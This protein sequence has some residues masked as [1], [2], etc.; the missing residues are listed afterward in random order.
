MIF[1]MLDPMRRPGRT[2]RSTFRCLFFLP[3]GER[4][5][6]EERLRERPGGFGL[7]RRGRLLLALRPPQRQLQVSRRQRGHAGVQVT[8]GGGGAG[9]GGG[10]GGGTIS[11]RT[12]GNVY[13]TALPF[14]PSLVSFPPSFLPIL[15]VHSGRGCDPVVQASA[16]TS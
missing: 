9:G 1:S 11:R 4:A 10:G 15:T 7:A 2:L 12:P 14:L 13:T 3:G 6:E 5:R 16:P 8:G